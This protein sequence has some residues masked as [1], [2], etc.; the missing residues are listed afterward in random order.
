VWAAQAATAWLL[1]LLLLLLVLLLLRALAPVPL[2]LVLVLQ[3]LADDRGQ[4]RELS[5]VDMN[6]RSARLEEQREGGS[7]HAGCQVSTLL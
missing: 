1:L 6:A 7:W 4:V 2:V 3:S 5:G